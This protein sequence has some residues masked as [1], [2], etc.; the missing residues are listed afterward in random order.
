MRVLL[1]IIGGI[2]V[3]IDLALCINSSRISRWEER[4]RGKDV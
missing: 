3:L 1:I 4:K 2:F